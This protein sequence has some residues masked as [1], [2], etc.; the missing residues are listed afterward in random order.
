MLFYKIEGLTDADVRDGDDMRTMRE[1]HRRLAVK[2]E[3]F[4]GRQADGTFCFVSELDGGA[5]TAGA[6]FTRPGKAGAVLDAFFPAIGLPLRDRTV[7][8]ITLGDVEDLLCAADRQDYIGDDDDVKER[9]G[10]DKITGRYTRELRYGENLIAEQ[11]REE[12]Q[13]AAEKYLMRSSLLPELDRIYTAPAAS[14]KGYGHPVHYLVQTDDRETRRETCRQLLCAL[15]ANHRLE[16]RRYAFLDFDADEDIREA[17]YDALYRASFGGAVI[18]RYNANECAEDSN[19]ATSSSDAIEIICETAKRYRNRV[20]TIFCLPQEC[21]KVKPIFYENLGTVTLVELQEEF[22]DAARATVFLKGLAKKAGVRP[23]KRLLETLNDEQGYLAPDLRARF[24]NWFNAKLKTA[25]YP[26]YKELAAVKTKALAAAPR[27]SAYDRLREMVGLDGVKD[28]LEKALAYYKMQKLYADKGFP[29]DRCS[30]HMVFTGNPGTAKTTVARLFAQILKDNGVLSR[31]HLVEVG[32]ADLVAR[33]VGWTAKTVQEKFKAA[34]GGVLFIDE[35]YALVEREGSYGDEAINTIVQEMENHREDV[36]VIFAGYPEP[37]ERFLD[38]NPGLR[39]RIAFHVPFA[40][41]D[42]RE[43][44]DIARLMA[45]DKSLCLTDDAMEKLALH[46]DVVRTQEDFGNGRC[47]RNLLEQA[48]M[49]QASRLL[50]VPFED[51]TEQDLK[52]IRAQDVASP[53]PAAE[54]RRIGFSA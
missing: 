21:A 53:P 37:M 8:E 51:I 40:D 12:I 54:P 9:F 24:D 27:G 29:C 48:R 50:T 52:T 47:V 19:L 33:Y 10:L 26:Q 5:V 25:V 13:Q 1:A 32:R 38:K 14:F 22:A 34:L 39:S 44:C 4:N 28:V 30:M 7:T 2:C 43:L 46:F 16:N 35:A 15:Y 17:I 31:G 20:L 45:K 42:T 49:N 6:I 3:K 11:S 23:D 36:V 18:V 41:Y